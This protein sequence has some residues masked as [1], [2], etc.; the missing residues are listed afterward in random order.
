MCWAA[1]A[2]AAVVG[3]DVGWRRLPDGGMEYIIQI[4]PHMLDMLKS[5]EQ[6]VSDIPPEL[7]EVR[8][9]RITVGT[10]ELPREAVLKPEPSSYVPQTISPPS[11]VR[12]LT[13]FGEQAASFV[14]QEVSPENPAPEHPD[15]A[16]PKESEEAEP[17]K[18]WL[19]LTLALAALFGSLGGTL[20]PGW[21][22]WDCRRD[23]KSVV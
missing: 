12:P 15:V 3:T 9:Y 23:R 4:E 17:P 8:S 1:I 16:E 14:K 7:W 5:G 19:P 21:G 18:P 6:I 11:D 22:A 13:D 2:L 10:D 20:G